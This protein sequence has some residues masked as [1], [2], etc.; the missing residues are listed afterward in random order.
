MFE[1]YNVSEMFWQQIEGY[2]CPSELKSFNVTLQNE[3]PANFNGASSDFFFV[4]DTCSNFAN[5]TKR[6][7]CK[8]EAESQNVIDSMYVLTKIQTQF[9]NTKSYLRNGLHMESQWL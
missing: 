8:S 5:I 4:V 3:S 1:R 9:W 6:T 2:L 7:D